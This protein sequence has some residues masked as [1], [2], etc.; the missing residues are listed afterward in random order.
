M[1]SYYVRTSGG[2][3]ANDGLSVA[4]GWATVSKAA[5]VAVA[6]DTVFLCTMNDGESFSAGSNFGNS[7]DGADGIILLTGAN[8]AGTVDGT[9]TVIDD[10]IV[11]QLGSNLSRVSFQYLSLNGGRFNLASA[12]GILLVFRCKS[13]NATGHA[14]DAPAFETIF[15][16]CYAENCTGTGF[17]LGTPNLTVTAISC[18]S[19]NN[20]TDGFE[21][22]TVVNCIA[23]NNGTNGFECNSIINCTAYNNTIG[24]EFNTAGS[25]HMIVNNLLV[26]NTTA[27]VGNN[28]AYIAKNNAFFANGTDLSTLPNS[29]ILVQNSVTLENDPFI[30]GVNNDF[31]LNGQAGGRACKHAGIPTSFTNINTTSFVDIGAHFPAFRK[32]FRT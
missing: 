12:I 22:H 17:N 11:A 28:N 14:F 7:G 8:S 26:N 5:G 21:G 1:A 10:D 19:I 23:A 30:S 2:D 3:D 29:D 32:V 25:A 6:G 20:A 27:I 31:T 13:I 9:L 15:V 16:E 24:I 18:V 4:N